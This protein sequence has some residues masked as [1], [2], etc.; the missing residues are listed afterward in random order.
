MQCK[1]C[2]EPIETARVQ[3]LA[4]KGKVARYCETC[5]ERLLRNFRR[6]TMS[7]AKHRALL[8]LGLRLRPP[9]TIIYYE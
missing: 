9:E 5:N 2:N 3:R 8:D 1:S 4:D 7:R 6:R